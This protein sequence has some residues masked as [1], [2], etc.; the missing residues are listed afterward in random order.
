MIDVDGL[1]PS[2]FA[3][4]LRDLLQVHRQALLFRPPGI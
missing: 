2:A 4:D 3:G 1:V